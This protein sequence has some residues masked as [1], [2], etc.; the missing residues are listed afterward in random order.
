MKISFPVPGR[1]PRQKQ[2]YSM[3]SRSLNE[4]PLVVKLRL[5]ALEAMEKEGLSDCFHSFISL[6]LTLFVPRSQLESIGDLDT[7]VTGVCDGLQAADNSSRLIL[8]SIF[9]DPQYK[10]ISPNRPLLIEDDSRVISIVAKKMPL[11]EDQKDQE[12]HYE[13]IVESME[14]T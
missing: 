6:K 7:F 13:V 12:V 14:L 4:A 9:L 11:G 10:E 3:W 5:S 8:H 1:P 2:G